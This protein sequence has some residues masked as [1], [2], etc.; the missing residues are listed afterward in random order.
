MRHHLGLLLPVVLAVTSCG[1]APS[2]IARSET[3][4]TSPSSTA[5]ADEA[6]RPSTSTLPSASPAAGDDWEQRVRDAKYPI[7]VAYGL[8]DDPSS[9]AIVYLSYQ[10]RL[11]GCLVDAGYSF[12]KPV[13]L[14]DQ[15]TSDANTD[16]LNELPLDQRQKFV[17]VEYDCTQEANRA[18]FLW[19]AVASTA[20]SDQDQMEPTAVDPNRSPEELRQWQIEFIIA[21]R[22]V[23]ERL[24]DE[25]EEAK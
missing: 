15:E 7:L 1:Q 25:L 4:A 16:A 20:E 10:R 2:T 21:H 12:F 24:A 17:S 23:M 5:L 13:P 22:D 18:T 19:P 14:G 8:P 6:S 3:P 9:E 11:A